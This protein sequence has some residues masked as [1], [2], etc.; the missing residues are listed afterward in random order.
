MLAVAPLVRERVRGIYRLT[1]AGARQLHEP[2]DFVASDPVAL[3]RAITAVVRTG[4]PLWLPRVPADSRT[5]EAIARACRGRAIVVVRSAEAHP[6]IALDETWLTP[7]RH[8]AAA[9]REQLRNSRRFAE[10]C[11]AVKT[12]IHVPRL[13]ELPALLDVALALTAA[14]AP[15]LG[16]SVFFRQVA[17]A[18]CVDGTLRI[19]LLRIGDRVAAA[20]V[21]IESPRAFWLLAGG[22]AARFADCAPQPLLLCEMI[23]YAAEA[24]LATF[25]FWGNTHA[26]DW[27][28]PQRKHVALATYPLN[29]RGAA[30]LAA[31]GAWACWRRWQRKPAG[32]T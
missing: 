28:T 11:G 24:S 16:T 3:R 5:P 32:T 19:C 12:E 27:Q 25:E 31:D 9:D 30:A 2:S 4:C 10:R 26:C 7:Q 6:Y 14:G 15:E 18:A 29:P 17:E 21:A 8:L 23:R 22:A 13:H 20:Q 1:S